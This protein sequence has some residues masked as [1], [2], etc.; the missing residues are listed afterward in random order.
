ME[1]LQNLSNGNANI[2]AIKEQLF[3]V[4]LLQL[5]PNLEGFNSPKSFGVYKGTGG[6]ALGVV[7]NVFEPTQP[8]LLFDAF[9]TCLYDTDCDMSKVEYNTLKGD[10]KIIFKAPVKT[11]G[12]KN[13]QGKSDESIVYLNVQ[14][15]YDG[16]TSTT[17]YLSMYRMI[18]ENGMKGWATEFE[19]KFKNTKNNVGRVNVL[20]DDVTKALMQVDTLEQGIKHLNTIEVKQNQIDEYLKK[21]V[22]YNQKDFNELNT[23]KRN[24]LNAINSSIA[25]EFDRTGSTLWGLVNGITHYTNH[26]A[27]TKNR[28]DYLFNDSGMKLNDKAQNVAFA[29]AN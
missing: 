22:G 4:K 14:T 1:I 6:D 20:C 11:M 23:N 13:M 24:I 16:K 19:S 25:I 12:F 7:G 27:N 17:L 8:K 26:V 9:E 29:M 15:G 18:C 3:D 28:L 10:R 21:V 2:E 5:H